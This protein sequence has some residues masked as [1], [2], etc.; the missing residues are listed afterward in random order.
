MGMMTI[1]PADN[2][3]FEPASLR[4][5]RFDF[6]RQTATGEQ[7]HN[8]L[9][10]LYAKGFSEKRAALFAGEKIN[11][12]EGRAAWHT[13]LRKPPGLQPAAV[14]NDL[15]QAKALAQAFRV[16]QRKLPGNHAVQDVVVLGIGGSLL[17]PQ[18]LMSALG[19]LKYRCHYI[20]NVDGHVLD[21]TFAQCD[22]ATTLFILI[23]KSFTTIETQMNANHCLAWLAKHGVQ[24]GKEQFVA[25]TANRQAAAQWGALPELTL[26]FEDWVGGRYSVW[27][28]VGFPV[29]LSIGVEAFDEISAGAY[30]VDKHFDAESI[31]SNLP[32]LMAAHEILALHR[33]ETSRCVA[34]YDERLAKLP[35]Y[36]QQLEMESLGKRVQVDGQAG[37]L[38]GPLVWGTV[39]TTG[40]HSVFQ[41][42]HQGQQKTP[43]DFIV[44]AQPHHEHEA[45]HRSMLANCLAQAQALST[46]RNA[47]E[48]AKALVAQGLP[49][50]E[51]IRLTPHMT[52]IGGRSSTLIMLPKLL[53]FY[54]GAMLSLYEHK[55]FVLSVAF[56]INAFDQYGVELGKLAAKK[57][58]SA[59][60]SAPSG[61]NLNDGVDATT[62][63]QIA[64]IKRITH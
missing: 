59:L 36:L 10:D 55:V 44:C 47:D 46:G 49:A 1:T 64:W 7:L 56:G 9:A 40:Q 60:L 26:G 63:N 4:G 27:S 25:I 42:L 14:S 24:N 35:D 38:C 23:S 19:P 37:S 43:V 3:I 28:A 15:A 13:V 20:G 50:D 29:M 32:V 30:E 54:I 8:V 45:L 6:S 58:E 31:E 62:Q 52:F 48:T 57:I 33:G 21:N 41:W 12:T 34:S 5:L 61:N 39:G 22:P 53:P 51:V 2:R 11:A 18:L 17:G 16:G